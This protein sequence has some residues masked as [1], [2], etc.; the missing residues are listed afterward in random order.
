MEEISEEELTELEELMDTIEDRISNISSLSAECN[1]MLDAE[2]YNEKLST[3]KAYYDAEDYGNAEDLLNE[4]DN[5]TS[6]TIAYLQ[7]ACDDITYVTSTIDELNILLE[8]SK[9]SDPEYY[10]EMQIEINRVKDILYDDPVSAK[11]TIDTI[12]EYIISN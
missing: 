2:G 6:S 1:Y 4:L 9:E 5:E 12:K 3:A 11:Q 8:Q 7:N 10:D